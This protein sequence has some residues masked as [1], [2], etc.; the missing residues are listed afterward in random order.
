MNTDTRDD[1]RRNRNFGLWLGIG[2]LVVYYVVF[3]SGWRTGWDPSLAIA[4]SL[5]GI[6]AQG[7]ILCACYYWAKYKNRN[8]VWTLWGWLAPFGFIPLALMKDQSKP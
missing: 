6:A 2:F 4:A 5:I 3:A 7:S 1:Y 8:A